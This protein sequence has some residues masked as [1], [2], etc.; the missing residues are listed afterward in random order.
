MYGT[1]SQSRKVKHDSGAAGVSAAVVML[2][3][4]AIA[5]LHSNIVY[6]T[7]VQGYQA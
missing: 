7:E 1:T 4:R 6:L 2:V 5:S 3:A